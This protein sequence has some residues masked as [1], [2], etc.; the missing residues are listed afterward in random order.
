MPMADAWKVTVRVG[1]SPVIFCLGL[2]WVTTAALG[3]ADPGFTPTNGVAGLKQPIAVYNN[4]SAYDELSDNIEL[5]EKLAMKELGE[6]LR[7]R[8]E[9]VRIDYYVM[10]AFWYSPNGGYRTF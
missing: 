1:L 9:G 10:D 6:I 8:R 3:Q 4:W 5:T 7:L 2:T